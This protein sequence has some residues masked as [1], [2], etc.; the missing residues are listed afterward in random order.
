MVFLVALMSATCYAPILNV[1]A[2]GCFD[3]D[4]PAWSPSKAK[5]FGFQFPSR[6]ELDSA[7]AAD[8]PNAR[9]G[10]PW[11]DDEGVYWNNTASDWIRLEGDTI[12]GRPGNTEFHT[13]GGDS[14]WVTFRT[15]AERFQ[16]WLAPSRTGYDGI[17]QRVNWKTGSRESVPIALR[18]TSCLPARATSVRRTPGYP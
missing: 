11:S 10:W 5:E 6:I 12:V 13:F 17:A 4:A 16:A 3:V 8:H 1:R 2:V 15:R 7:F 14:I 18:R 9:R